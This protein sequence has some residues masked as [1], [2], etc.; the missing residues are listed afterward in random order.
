MGTF[1][2][3]LLWFWVL[4]TQQEISDIIKDIDQIK[5][6]INELKKDN[7]YIMQRIIF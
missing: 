3:F 4:I 2:A 7:K 6:D 5:K 1:F